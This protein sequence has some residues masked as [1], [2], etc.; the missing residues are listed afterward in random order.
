MSFGSKS[1]EQR[2]TELLCDVCATLDWI[3]AVQ[4]AEDQW[5]V[6]ELLSRL[7]EIRVC[8]NAGL[9]KIHALCAYE[10]SKIPEKTFDALLTAR[11]YMT[12]ASEWIAAMTVHDESADQVRDHLRLTGTHAM[13]VRVVRTTLYELGALWGDPHCAA[14]LPR[15]ARHDGGSEE[16][17]S[18]EELGGSSS[19]PS[20][21]SRAMLE[22]LHRAG[23]HT[24]DPK[25]GD[26]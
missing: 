4:G 8:A 1:K 20:A 19:L 13:E 6:L 26:E 14:K 7:P 15:A 24:I 5:E 16:L 25:E 21:V 9:V 12:A 23:D 18:H 11:G 17:F 10:R 3:T 2:L 22:S